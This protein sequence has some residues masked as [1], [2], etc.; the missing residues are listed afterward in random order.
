VPSVELAAAAVEDLDELI[1]THSLPPDTRTRVARS[2][3][4]LER[5][6][7]MGPELAG[8]WDG[9]RFFLGPWRWL[10]LIY[11]YL[12][13][14]DRVVVL[15]IRDARSA[16]AATARRMNHPPG[17]SVPSDMDVIAVVGARESGG[18]P[19]PSGPSGR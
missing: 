2:L 8:R 5:F 17:S 12:E 11:P 16:T 1:R 3:R 7:L 6:P 10:L 13:D 4:G 19:R 14:E 18:S 15:T 9:M